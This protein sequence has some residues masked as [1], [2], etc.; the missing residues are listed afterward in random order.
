MIDFLKGSKSYIVAGLM[1]TVTVLHSLGQ[2]D[3]ANYQLLMSLLGAGAVTT[4]AAKINRMDD[5]NKYKNYFVLLPILFLLG[6]SSAYAQA[7]TPT[8]KYDYTNALP[9]EVA[10]YTQ[11]I[12]IDNNSITN[13]INC[14]A[15]GATGTTCSVSI[16]PLTSGP[17]VFVVT[18]IK[19]GIGASAQATFDPAN[20][21]KTPGNIRYQVITIINI[22]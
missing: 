15:L 19:G 17:H 11:T 13:P 7:A 10:T 22:P 18:A 12:T 1:V 14:V 4:V 20:T 3:D 5:R 2:I 21:P 8:L 9:T 6:S 16:S